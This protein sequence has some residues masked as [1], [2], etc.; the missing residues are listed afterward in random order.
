MIYD[1]LYFN[2]INVV[3]IKYFN[4]IMINHVY[5]MIYTNLSL[6][7]SKIASFIFVAI[8][9]NWIN[10]MKKKAKKAQNKIK[11]AL[12]DRD[13]SNKWLAEE[14]GVSEN[15]VSLWC[16]NKVQPQLETFYEIA[17]RLNIEVRKL[18][19]P[20]KEKDN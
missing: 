2:K 13:K 6:N 18:I 4:L 20:T 8:Q 15:T 11:A 16:K 1:F 9:K 19:V 10:A 14:L 7:T 17:E 5:F 3:N 12:A